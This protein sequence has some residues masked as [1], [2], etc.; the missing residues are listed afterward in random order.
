MTT[1]AALRVL[2]DL[3]GG[4][5]TWEKLDH[6]LLFN[7]EGVRK[8]SRSWP[9]DFGPHDYC[10]AF[11]RYAKEVQTSPYGTAMR[12][13]QSLQ[14][15]G[16]YTNEVRA[17]VESVR[18]DARDDE[19]E[20]LLRRLAEAIFGTACP[21]GQR[22]GAPGGDDDGV[23][24]HAAEKPRG[25]GGGPAAQAGPA[26]DDGPLVIVPAAATDRVT[27]G[28]LA[29]TLACVPGT[30]PDA[31]R[32]LG[33]LLPPRVMDVV[34][35]AGAFD[36]A[37]E[38]RLGPRLEDE[39]A[40]VLRSNEGLAWRALA[41]RAAAAVR[42]ADRSEVF[43]ALAPLHERLLADARASGDAALDRAVSRAYTCYLR[44]ADGDL[45][46]A[47]GLL[48]LWGLVG[49]RQMLAVAG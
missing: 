12:V 1:K 42:A 30:A 9:R 23:V 28:Q 32:F 46:R 43:G 14:R 11:E 5:M 17:I 48:A 22:G 36:A 8:R 21:E 44:G 15:S 33:A 6:D 19:A 39:A 3:A 24:G 35:G 27:L 26:D 13:R 38:G 10:D 34:A 31:P 47:F 2:Y 45:A 18:V 16:A 7:T 29:A 25:P 4:N 41:R 37:M 40:R 49:P 20:P